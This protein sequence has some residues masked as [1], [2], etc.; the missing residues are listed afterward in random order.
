MG[1]TQID[2]G[3]PVADLFDPAW[4]LPELDL[5]Q[6]G[7][8]APTRFTDAE[9]QKVWDDYHAGEPSRVPVMLSTNDRVVLLDD[10]V[11]SGDLDYDQVFGDPEAM[12][13]ASLLWQYVCRRRH[14]LFCDSPTELPETWQVSVG[15]QNVYEAHFFG[16]PIDFPD[17][18]VPDTRPI[19]NDDNKRSI[20]DTDIDRPLERPPFKTAVEYYEFLVDYVADKTF[21]DR[22]IK[23]DPPS[24]N[25]SDGPLTNAMSVRGPDILIEM[26]TDPEYAND[27]F[28]F[29]IEAAVK[30]RL[31]F[32][33]H[34]DLPDTPPGFADDSIALIGEDLYQEMLLPH[35]RRWYEATGSEYGKRGIHLCGDATRHFP[36]IHEELGVVSFDTGFPVDFA[37]LREVLGQ[38]VEIFG[39]VEVGVLKAGTA[40]QVYARAREILASGI[41]AGGRFVL[42]EA[43]NLP[44]NV[45]WAN[46]AAMYKA[47]L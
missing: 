9:K 31:A 26:L 34:F 8:H 35:H 37:W 20:F 13:R 28:S 12:L 23:V 39:G 43:N 17:D 33:E 22:P 7:P 19:L 4:E 42:H 29:F 27:L 15:F 41:T 38:D 45:P 11:N 40:D 1:K 30:R 3:R 14:H 18:Q 36:K 32:I 10:R 25:V 21:L 6:C 47:A 16:C 46:L 5:A 2:G 24:F 44:P